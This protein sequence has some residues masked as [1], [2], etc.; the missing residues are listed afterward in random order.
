MRT[1]DEV[2]FNEKIEIFVLDRMKVRFSDEITS[3]TVVDSH[4]GNHESP[5]F[6]R[7]V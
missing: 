3:P 5:R 7:Q 2:M 6:P 4:A 1:G